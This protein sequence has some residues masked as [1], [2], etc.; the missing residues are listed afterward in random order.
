[1]LLHREAR[2]RGCRFRL[3]FSA[4]R[5][6]TPRL[7]SKGQVDPLVKHGSEAA[8]P[9][10]CFLLPRP[11]KIHDCNQWEVVIESF[12]PKILKFPECELCDRIF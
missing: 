2:G 6:E 7:L 5:A 9:S 11:Q 8:P 3:Y 12:A 10:P 4:S 1:V